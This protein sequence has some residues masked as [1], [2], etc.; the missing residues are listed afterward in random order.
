[1]EQLNKSG[2][3]ASRHWLWLL[4]AVVVIWFANL[5]Y[6]T[7]TSPDEGRYAE[8]PREMVASGDW[9]TPRLNGLK[10]FEKPALQYWATATAYMLF[11]QHNW[12][13]RLWTAL[14]ALGGIFAVWFAGK[15]LFGCSAGRYAALVLS[16]SML[17][18]LLGH[19]NTL[20]MGV[21]FFMSAG[22]LGFLLAQRDGVASNERRAWMWFTWAAL[23]LSVLSKG[24]IGIVL[25][26]AVL[27]LYTLIERDFS[28]WRRLQLSSGL[29]IFF[30][31][32]APWF[33]AVSL[34]NP[35]FAHF[36]FIHEHFDR[37]LTKVHGRYRPWWDFIPV[38]LLGMLP[39]VVVTLDALARA[40]KLDATT[41]SG[42]KP[43]RFLLLWCVF[44]FVF[45][46]A[47][48]SKLPSYILPIFPAL[49]LLTGVRLTQIRPRVLFWQIAPVALLAA[50]A[51]AMTP[52]VVNF[53]ANDMEKP[54]Y[55]SYA[56]WAL[57]AAI[58]WLS[59]MLL[60]LYFS[61]RGRVTATVTTLSLAGLV[62]AQ[63]VLSGHESLAP[64]GSAYNIARQIEPYVKPD[65]H[66]FSIGM[67]EQTLPV[68]LN[69]TFTLVDFQSEMEFGLQQEPDKWIPDMETFST[70]WSRQP[71]A[72]AIMYPDTYARLKQKGLPMQIIANDTVRIVVKTP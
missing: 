56:Q 66:F 72:L 22:L 70:V 38:L 35:E 7:L 51:L 47:S 16:S 54:L 6:C 14:T 1:M 53:A 68:Y 46:S 26:G 29:A 43:Q 39:W 19:F 41:H 37:F 30:A 28:L 71:Y 8:I 40:W 9:L 64:S 23:A 59:G 5:E 34:A 31:I 32:C 55:A 49:A 57:A 24:L 44:I 61:Y 36:F 15:R 25:P 60:G 69:R 45:F 63:L 52:H 11:G 10:Y 21:T 3:G 2:M 12:T 50:I 62:A 58:V 65:V 17:F 42:I 4:L 48:D 67:Y 18:V 27:V 33:I 13:A 20:D